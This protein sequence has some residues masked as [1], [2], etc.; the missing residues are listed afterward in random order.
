MSKLYLWR[1]RQG[2]AAVL[3]SAVALTIGAMFVVALAY[4]WWPLYVGI[5]LVFSLLV[6]IVILAYLWRIKEA[7]Q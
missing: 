2:A 7:G 6:A 5:M 4:G 3:C 1:W